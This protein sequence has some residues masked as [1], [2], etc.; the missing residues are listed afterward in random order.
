[1]TLDWWTLPFSRNC[2]LFIPDLPQSIIAPA[3]RPEYR[4]EPE[5]IQ[6][7]AVQRQEAGDD[8]PEDA[9][10]WHRRGTLAPRSLIG[11]GWCLSLARH[12]P[13]ASF[14]T[15]PPDAPQDEVSF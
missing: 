7:T 6:P 9:L 1:M 2:I 12:A 13:R 15:R 14:E 11:R 3:P 10:A 5:P 4:W 8:R